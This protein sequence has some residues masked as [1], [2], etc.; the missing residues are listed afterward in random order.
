MKIAGSRVTVFPSIAKHL[1]RSMEKAL[2][3]K[4]QRVLYCNFGEYSNRMY[5]HVYFH[6]VRIVTVVV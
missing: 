4:I 1:S 2:L 5:A 3:Y 6:I